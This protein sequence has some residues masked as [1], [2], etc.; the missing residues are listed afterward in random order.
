M[1]LGRAWKGRLRLAPTVGSVAI[2]LAVATLAVAAPAGAATTTLQP[3]PEGARTFAASAA[4]WTASVRQDGGGLTCS[5]LLAIPGVTCPIVTNGWQAG[6]GDGFVR[7]ALSTAVGLLSSTT[8]D[9]TSPSFTLAARPDLA[10]FAFALRGT[11]GSLLNLGGATVAADLVDAAGGS[12]P[13]P[14]VA[15]TAVAPSAGFKDYGGALAPASL[16][17]GHRYV[18]RVRMVVSTP[19]G[20]GVAGSLDL[21]DV[22]L[23]LVDLDPPTDLTAAVSSDTVGVRVSGSVDPHGQA[24][25]V[26]ADYGTTS[27]YGITT[28]TVTTGSGAQPYSLPLAGLRPAT[29]YHYR[30]TARSADGTLAT[31]DG[32]FSSPAEAAS[33]GAPMLVGAGTSRQRIAVFDLDAAVTQ[34]VVEVYDAAGTRLLLTFP[35]GD[36]DGSATIALPAAAGRYRVRVVRTRAGGPVPSPFADATYDAAPPDTS[37]TLVIVSP[38]SSAQRARTVTVLG[39]PA[40]VATR[41]LQVLDGAERAVGTPVALGAD[42]TATVTLPATPGSYRVRATFRDGGG[43]EATAR[44]LQAVLTGVAPATPEP[45]RETTDPPTGGGTGGT[46]TGGAGTGGGATPGSGAGAISP[47]A[48][49][50]ATAARV[51][52]PYPMRTAAPCAV[53]PGS[54]IR[55]PR[56]NGVCPGRRVV[57]RIAA[58]RGSV[59]GVRV[60]VRAEVPAVIGGSDPLVFTLAGARGLRSV[61]WSLGARAL[62]SPVVGAALLRGD[63]GRQVLSVRL[64][65][66]RGRAVTIRLAFRTRAV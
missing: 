10:A 39:A 60:T 14:L 23:Q 57:G 45:R 47:G 61:R 11:S 40:G 28:S 7:S 66:R 18:V 52:I 64:V 54:S 34:A 30:V 56:S 37:G 44:S 26:T 21:D 4:G 3:Q 59:G 49:T 50:G 33:D 51:T 31:T 19:V 13:I 36:L 46:G 17:A 63:G 41:E 22:G 48:G 38:W 29:R 5:G 12:S 24:T 27:A 65:P 53:R 1:T 25:T 32:T 42:D 2:A 6:S 20:V 8:I 35:D 55:P 62:R 15:A 16:T 58:Q 43:Q 9:W